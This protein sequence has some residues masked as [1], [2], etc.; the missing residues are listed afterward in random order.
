MS[1]KKINMDSIPFLDLMDDSED[2][3]QRPNKGQSYLIEKLHKFSIEDSDGY[4]FERPN[5]LRSG[6][7]QIERRTIVD[8]C[9]S[10]SS[11]FEDIRPPTRAN[12][13][14]ANDRH[15]VKMDNELGSSKE[16]RSFI[17]EKS[18]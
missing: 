10:P 2:K 1:S 15:F 13:P 6:P 17:V 8:G 4:E 18:C 5:I 9:H 12:N 16:E 14:Q 3:Y 11:P 7:G